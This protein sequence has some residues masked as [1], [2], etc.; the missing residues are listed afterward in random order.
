MRT[1]AAAFERVREIASGNATA[2]GAL[3]DELGEEAR[4]P[5]LDPE[6]IRVIPASTMTIRIRVGPPDGVRTDPA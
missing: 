6:S 4:K 2:V 5:D 1:E 3:I